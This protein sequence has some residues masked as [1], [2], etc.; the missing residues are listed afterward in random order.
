VKKD[1]KEK[2]IAIAVDVLDGVVEEYRLAYK[3][4][5]NVIKE[6]ED[7][8]DVVDVLSTVAVVKG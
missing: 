4:I 1:L 7:L 8:I 5:D 3:N 2:N 6:Q